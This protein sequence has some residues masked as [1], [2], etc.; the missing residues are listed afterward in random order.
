M[1][2]QEA[3]RAPTSALKSSIRRSH[4]GMPSTRPAPEPLVPSLFEIVDAHALLLHPG[5]VPEFENPLASKWSARGR[6]R[7]RSFQMAAEDFAG[8]DLVEPS[9]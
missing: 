8:I 6:D 5:E 4:V 9:P 1:P 2:V 3:R 7:P